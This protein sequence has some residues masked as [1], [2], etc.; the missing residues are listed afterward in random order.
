MKRRILGVALVA[1]AWCSLFAVVRHDTMKTRVSAHGLLHVAIAEQCATDRGGWAT[2]PDNPLFA[3]TPLPYYYVFHEVALGLAQRLHVGLLAAFELLALGATALVVV[4]G[5][6]LGRRLFRSDAAGFATSFLVFAGAH[7]QGPLVLLGRWLQY[8]DQLFT[9]QGFAADGA[10]LWGLVHPA[11]GAMRLGDPWGTLGPLAVYFLNVTA[12]PVALAG[13]LTTV[14]MVVLAATRRGVLPLLPVAAGVM[15]T[16]LFSPITGLA[17]GGALASGLLV[18][19]WWRRRSTAEMLAPR[20][21]VA[22]AV[23]LAVGV[24]LAAP[25]FCHL[26]GRGDAAGAWGLNPR[27]L[28]GVAA[29]GWLVA[30]LALLVLRRVAGTVRTLVLALLLAALLLTAATAFLTLP[31]GNEDNFFHAALLLLA[32]PAAGFAVTRWRALLLHLAFAP[33]LAIVLLSYRGRA[34]IPLAL[35]ADGTLERTPASGSLARLNAF[36]RSNTPA[37]AIVVQDP[38]AAGRQCTGN[39]S[40]LPALTGHALFTDYASHYLVAPHADAQR[41][42]SINRA[43]VTGEPLSA[44]DAGY[45]LALARPVYIVVPVGDAV[46]EARL[47]GRYGPALFAAGAIRVFEWRLPP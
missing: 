34:E 24:A 4:A 16:T 9:N 40:E 6:G 8:G 15:V 5:F 11:V 28:A 31:V 1:V 19:S 26:L 18:A 45:L 41:R 10:Y 17:G 23:A 12:R 43:L 29:A 21:A 27:R 32:V 35:A 44:A 33:T 20:R 25:W 14:W 22:I 46:A 38:G 37:A 42:A 13:L 7:P 30:S 47:V 36:L 39:T 3:G 2:A